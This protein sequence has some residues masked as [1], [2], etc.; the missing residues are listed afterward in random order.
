MASDGSHGTRSRA[1]WKCAAW[2]QRRNGFVIS[3]G[4][5]NNRPPMA[6]SALVSYLSAGDGP[7]AKGSTIGGVIGA[8]PEVADELE[9]RRVLAMVEIFLL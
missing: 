9:E 2:S 7:E 3:E 1:G 4:K 6:S 5:V 8:A